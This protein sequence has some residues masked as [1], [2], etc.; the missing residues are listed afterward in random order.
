[1]LN[2]YQEERLFSLVCR[3][4]G[5]APGFLVIDLP[6]NMDFTT[7][8]LRRGM[9]VSLEG[10]WLVVGEVLAVDCRCVRLWPG[11][12]RAALTWDRE[13]LPPNNLQALQAAICHW[14]T[15]G[16]MKDIIDHYEGHP[17]A[18]SLNLLARGLCYGRVDD[19][20]AAVVGILGYGPGLTPAGDD[21]VVGLA[22]AAGVGAEYQV[23]LPLLRQ[24]IIDNLDRTTSLSAHILRQVLAGDYHEYLQEVLYSVTRGTPEN[25][26]V[27]VRNLMGLGATSG[28]DIATG[29]YLAFL[30][31]LESRPGIYEEYRQNAGQNLSQS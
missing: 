29:L 20:A 21:L 19:L 25:V 4:T 2:L 1:M 28:T 30:W 22:A 3:G 23:Y 7:L 14:G 11:R 5:N 8:G 16:G 9:S 17:L 24:A 12:D 31:Q 6:E 26:T 18:A 15:R 10:E 13:N 27:A